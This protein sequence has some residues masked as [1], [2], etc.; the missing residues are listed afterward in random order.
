M[1]GIDGVID[2]VIDDPGKC[3]F[4]P[5][6]LE[7]GRPGAPT[8]GTCLTDGEADAAPEGPPLKESEEVNA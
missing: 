8:D 2:G 3:H 7:C 1:N 5:H 4:N 6:V